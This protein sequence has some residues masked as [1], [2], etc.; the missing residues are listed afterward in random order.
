[1]ASCGFSVTA[2][3]SCT[4]LHQRP[5]KISNAE[6]THSV[7]IF[8]AVMQNHGDSRK[9]RHTTSKSHDDRKCVIILQC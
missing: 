9:S 6:I 3:L 5:F 4:G 2:Q 7:V 1:M 8:T